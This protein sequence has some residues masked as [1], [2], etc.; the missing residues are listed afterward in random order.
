MTPD[1]MREMLFEILRGDPGPVDEDPERAAMRERLTQQV[2]EIA[3]KGGIVEIP[4]E[5]EV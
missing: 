1:E 3:A 2:E 5:I 4:P